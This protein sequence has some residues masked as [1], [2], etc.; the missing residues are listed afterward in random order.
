MT[1]VV[2]QAQGPKFPSST[3]IKIKKIEPDTDGPHL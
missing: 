3:K 1:Q 2:G